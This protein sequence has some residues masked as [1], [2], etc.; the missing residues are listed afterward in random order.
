[1]SIANSPLVKTAMFAEDPNWGRIL[2]SIGK[3]SIG[4]Y[5][6]LKLEIYLGKFLIFKNNKLNKKYSEKNAAKY[7]KNKKIDINIILNNGNDEVTVWT[8]DL[9]YKYIKI[10]AEYRT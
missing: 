4:K 3:A 5:N 10:N 8:S 2:S 7:L 9:S 1:M 6:F